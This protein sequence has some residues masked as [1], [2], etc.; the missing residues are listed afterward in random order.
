V[1]AD[2]NFLDRFNDHFNEIDKELEKSID[3]NMPLIEE[4]GRHS[5]L[6]QGKRLRPLLFVLSALMN[7]YD[8]KDIYYISII[9]EYIHCASLLHDD[10]IDNAETRRKKPS[11]SNVWGD[12]AALLTGDYM[13]SIAS[14][15][16]IELRIYDILKILHDA[17]ARMTEGQ[18]KE[19]VSTGKWDTGEAEYLEII[20]SKT[21]EL[22][23]A[24]CASG[25]VIAEA[26]DRECEYLKNFGLNMG[27]S[28]QMVDDLLDY[29]SSEKDFGKPVGKDVR[30]GKITLPLIYA[31][32]TMNNSE[33]DKYKETFVNGSN[34]DSDYDELISFVRESGAIEKTRVKA[35]QY[36]EKAALYLENF[37]ETPYRDDLIALNDY[38]TG[39]L[40]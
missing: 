8:K 33:V 21:A 15:I 20:T 23:S 27:I 4:I 22:I 10:V 12:S 13:F 24:S 30:E 1:S 14:G 19:L 6:A 38:M 36:V 9:F 3:S 26:G 39:R 31:I 11:A 34:N 5:L 18:I 35:E 40:Y 29:S 37:P 2:S 25:A 16:A 7:G 32:S 17:A 28:F